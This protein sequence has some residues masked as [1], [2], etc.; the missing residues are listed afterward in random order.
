VVDWKNDKRKSIRVS[1]DVLLSAVQDSKQGVWWER[2]S[3]S[4]PIRASIAPSFAVLFKV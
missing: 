4:V 2:I 1:I 3:R